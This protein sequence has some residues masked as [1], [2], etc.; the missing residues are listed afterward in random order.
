MDNLKNNLDRFSD[1]VK[2][3]TDYIEQLKQLDR[4]YNQNGRHTEQGDQ[5][6]DARK[7][8]IKNL[9]SQVNGV[10]QPV[11]RELKQYKKY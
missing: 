9:S 2:G 8:F 6:A 3:I 10:I 5:I 7:N 4:D 1:N 11:I